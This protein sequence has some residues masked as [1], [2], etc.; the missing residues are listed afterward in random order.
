MAIGAV[1]MLIIGANVSFL[2]RH[3]PGTGGIYT[4]TKEVLGRKHLASCPF[5]SLILKLLISRII[6]EIYHPLRCSNSQVFTNVSYAAGRLLPWNA[7]ATNVVL[8]V[9]GSVTGVPVS[10]IA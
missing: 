5:Q 7:S 9:I 2:M 6:L 8:P 10:S 4:Y 3:K 1:V